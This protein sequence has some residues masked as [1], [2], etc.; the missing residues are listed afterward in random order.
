MP[1]RLEVCTIDVPNKES[2]ARFGR[3]SRHEK[4]EEVVGTK[5]AWWRCDL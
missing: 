1:L 3:G 2:N 4:Q 5:S